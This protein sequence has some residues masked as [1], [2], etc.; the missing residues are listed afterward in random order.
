MGKDKLVLYQPDI[1]V[2]VEVRLENENVCPFK[3]LLIKKMVFSIV[4]TILNKE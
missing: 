2:A 3:Y 1:T 4:R